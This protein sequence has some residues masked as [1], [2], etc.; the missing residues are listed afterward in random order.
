[1]KYL[2]FYI[3]EIEKKKFATN[4]NFCYPKDIV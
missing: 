3:G 4:K 2:L 1:M